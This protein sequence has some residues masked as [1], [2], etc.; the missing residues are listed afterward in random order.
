M[1]QGYDYF[2]DERTGKRVAVSIA[3][4]EVYDTITRET[5]VGTIFYTPEQQQA[6]EERKI[7]EAKKEMS[8]MCNKPLGNFFFVL[9]NEQFNNIP[10]ESV[11]RLIFLSTF[12]R[13]KD[14]RLMITERTPMQYRDLPQILKLSESTVSRFWSKVCPKYITEDENGLILSRGIMF[15]KGRLKSTPEHSRYQRF[16]INSVRKLYNSTDKRYH[17]HL[18]Y[19]FKLLP[20]VNIEYNLICHNPLETELDEIDLLSVADFCK[21]IGHDVAHV[22]KLLEIYRNLCFDVNGTQEKF[23][24]ITYDGINKAGAKI[25]INPHILYSGSNY[26]QV[27]II[28]TFCKK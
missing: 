10:P 3:T 24:V 7:A 20:F 19:I 17:K 4:G 26:E 21:L 2:T 22:N 6:Y 14:K 18:G 23:C 1:T 5:P 28:G 16:Y 25:C 27:K 13:Y 9:S 12:S 8:R 15:Q 11:A